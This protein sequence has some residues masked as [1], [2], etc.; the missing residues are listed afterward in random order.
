MSRQSVLINTS[1]SQLHWYSLLHQMITT[2]KLNIKQIKSDLIAK[3]TLL[4]INS[5]FYITKMSKKK[6][7]LRKRMVIFGIR[8]LVAQISLN[9]LWNQTFYP[10]VSAS[11]VLRF[12]ASAMMPGFRKN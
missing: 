5:L 6:I 1:V 7:N 11:Q 4:S 10:P 8:S 12:R 3:K 2:I 9:L